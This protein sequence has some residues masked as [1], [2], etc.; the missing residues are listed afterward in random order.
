MKQI[1]KNKI[2]KKEKIKRIIESIEKSENFERAFTHTS[3]CNENLKNNSYETLEFLGD[4]IL[5]FHTS[6][7][8][9]NNFPN[10]SEG[11]MSKLKQLMVQESTLA[12]LSREIGLGDY[13]N[14]GSGEKKNQGI[15]KNSILADIFESFTAALFLEKGFSLSH[16]F[17]SLTLFDW[18]KGK[19]DMVWD[20][21]SRLQEYC[22]ARKNEIK[23]NLL[24]TKKEKNQ[25]IF[26]MEVSDEMG[27]FKETGEGKSKKEAEQEAASK[28]IRLF[29]ISISKDK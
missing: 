5:N 15:N 17:L 14:L 8:I 21:K 12:H 22:Q 27:S 10:Y 26:V 1:N 23:Y 19:E 3:Y 18:I 7:F 11:K 6:F 13:L 29:K 2:K 4:S 25:Q 9:Y 24:D 28:V 16:K 20:Y